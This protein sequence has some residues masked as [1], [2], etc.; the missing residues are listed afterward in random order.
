MGSYVMS[1]SLETGCYRHIQI[2]KSATLYKLHKAIL[3]AFEFEDDHAHAFFMDNK[4]WSQANAYY[5]MKMNGDEMLT[6]GRRLEKLGLGKGN[7]FKYVFDFGD[8]WQFQCRVLRELEEDTKQPLVLR[9]VGGSPEQYPDYDPEYETV[10]TALP[11]VLPQ[12]AILSMFNTLP[13]P[14]ETVERIHKYFEA[15]ARLY[16][17]IPVLKLLELY[18]SQNEPVEEEVFLQ[19]AEIIR[20][21]GNSFSVL[22][23]EDLEGVEET[24]PR[25]WDVIEDS[26]LMIDPEEYGQLVIKQ[27]NK[28]YK[29]LPKD[30]FIKYADQ[31][32]Y[33]VT[34]QNK[35]MK[36]YLF[37][38]RGLR[39]PDGVWMGIEDMIAMDFSLDEM[40][41]CLEGEGLIFDSKEDL[42]EFAALY[43]ELNNNTR[44]QCNRGHTP[45]ELFF[46]NRRRTP[47]YHWQQPEDQFSVF[48][49]LKPAPAQAPTIVKL[50]SRNGPCPC[51]SGLKYKRCCG[52]QK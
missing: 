26:L 9:R 5:S 28:P 37:A 27:G 49:G 33:P 40:M 36:K 34:P 20:H 18:N 4:A 19:L 41:R 35:A 10:E 42:A 38:K 51:G 13:I 11:M 43:Q 21:E 30:E 17:V 48:D 7:R 47:L 44:K 29:I 45:D 8:N 22:C 46:G 15:A 52:K 39:D 31:H 3:D 25:K 14:L 23:P 6:K 12:R 16:G 32:Y 24:D 50:P 1:V 2:S